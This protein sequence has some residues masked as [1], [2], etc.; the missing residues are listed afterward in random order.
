M[1]DA[2]KDKVK[3][4][5]NARNRGSSEIMGEEAVQEEAKS[6]WKTIMLKDGM[7][8]SMLN[9][10][11]CGLKVPKRQNGFIE[12]PIKIGLS[13]RNGIQIGNVQNKLPILD[14]ASLN[15]ACI[16]GD[17]GGK[18]SD[19]SPSNDFVVGVFEP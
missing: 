7:N 17:Y 14:E 15:G 16:L 4:R 9:A 18:L 1:D 10:R 12:N 5:L 6:T 8:P 19:I 3:E 13:P 2:Y 11:E